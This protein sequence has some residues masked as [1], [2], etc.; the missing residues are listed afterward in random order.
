MPCTPTDDCKE[1]SVVAGQ[2]QHQD[3]DQ[4]ECCT[5]FC[6]CSACAAHFLIQDFQPNINQ[7][8]VINS[9]HTVEKDA[10]ICSAIIP[11][12]QP[13]KVVC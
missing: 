8:A 12:W 13:P 5:P 3:E 1:D 4:N 2:R 10:E 9:I 11:I 6:V 7:T